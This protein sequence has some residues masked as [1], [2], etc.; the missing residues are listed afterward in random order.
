[1]L[2]GELKPILTALVLPPVAPLLLALLGLVLAWGKR[3]RIGLA[4]IGV[5]IAALWLLSCYPVATRLSEA[6]LPPVQAVKPEDLAGVQAIVVLGGG[7]LPAAPEY[8]AAQPAT[9][10]LGRLRYGAWLARRTGKP[11]AFAGGVGWAAADMQMPPEAEVAARAVQDFGVTLRWADSKSRDTVENANEMKR[12][13]AADGVTRIALV[14]DFWHM[15]RS[16]LAFERAGFSVLPAPT[17]FPAPM[18]RPLLAWLPSPEGLALS[19]AVIREA[20]GLW[21]AR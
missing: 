10:T 13:L 1:M 7:T 18:V 21:V 4:L 12:L 16:V 15:P 19:R 2:S 20:L 11:L 14:T 17:G 9:P 8:G 6:L 5:S 3:A